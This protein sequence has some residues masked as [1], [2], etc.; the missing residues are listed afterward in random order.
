M[1]W[2]RI[3]RFVTALVLICQFAPDEVT[4]MSPLSPSD[5]PPPPPPPDVNSTHGPG[6]PVEVVQRT[7]SCGGLVEQSHTYWNPVPSSRI[8]D[9]PIHALSSS[10]ELMEPGSE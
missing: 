10:G 2:S 6:T 5:T 8:R 9:S 3:S 7:I 4:V 1:V